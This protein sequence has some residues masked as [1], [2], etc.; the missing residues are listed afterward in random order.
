MSMLKFVDLR[1]SGL[2]PD[3]QFAFLDKVT[4]Q[5]VTFI[6]PISEWARIK[7]TCFFDWDDF[8]DC[9]RDSNDMEEL[10]DLC[11]EWV[12]KYDH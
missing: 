7:R 12:F 6:Q 11:P 5:F 2:G 3:K 10:R 4:D 9:I 1:N 8:L